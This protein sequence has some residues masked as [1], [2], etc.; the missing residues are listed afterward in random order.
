[1]SDGTLLS[2]DMVMP[3]A[4]GPF[5]VLFDYYPYRKDDLS[6]YAL[7]RQR[8][9]AQRGYVALR[10]DVRGTGSSRGIAEDEY[11]LQEQLDAV[12]AIDWMSQQPWSTGRVGMFGISYGGFNSLQVAMHRPPALKAICPICFTDNRYTDDCHYK[13]G[14]LQML[15]D[16]ATYGLSMVVSNALPPYPQA[17]GPDWAAAWEQR[18]EHNRVVAR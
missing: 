18:L 4:A 13:G 3:D 10:V 7:R 16:I 6:A 2:A 8:Y 15:F 9:L 1:M 5:P 14:A 17:T 11:V 12:E